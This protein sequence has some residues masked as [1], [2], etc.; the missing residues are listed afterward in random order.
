MIGS[1]PYSDVDKFFTEINDL[2]NTN[3]KKIGN[4]VGWHQ[5]IGEDKVGDVATAQGLLINQYTGQPTD[6]ECKETLINT[7]IIDSVNNTGC[8]A[9]ISNSDTPLVSAT[10][11]ITTAIIAS[12]EPVSSEVIQKAVNW[13]NHNQND[14]GGW[15]PNKGLPSRIYDTFLA[16]RV[17]KAIDPYNSYENNNLRNARRW[18]AEAQNQDGGWGETESGLS[19]PVHTA[20]ALIALS[21]NSNPTND[22][23]LKNGKRYLYSQWQPLDAWEHTSCTEVYEIFKDGN[24]S[25]LNR[26]SIEHYSTPWAIS[27]LLLCGESIINK[28]LFKSLKWLL[29]RALN[30]D[31]KSSDTK[32]NGRF[33]AMH[34]T[35]FALQ[36]FKNKS[37]NY[38]FERM[39]FINKFIFFSTGKT[40]LVSFLII[41]APIFLL[42]LIFGL[43]VDE[44][45]SMHIFNLI[46]ANKQYIG[47]IIWAMLI[48][49]PLLLAKIKIITWKDAII[50][51]LIPAVLGITFDMF[52]MS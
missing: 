42:G 7:Q 3:K 34:D 13:I 32:P 40:Q 15:G 10:S 39:V 27:A 20:Y 21:D 29:T 25:S 37:V 26:I 50:G 14:D 41:T 35:V 4:R 33:W 30:G 49:L 43:L 38:G 52:I 11:W 31:F 12:G 8:W 23:L 45:K 24:S 9:F 17:L 44:D 36:T 2:L 6:K 47:R 19:T 28:K 51:V 16:T 5:F 1:F 46:S 18:I 48:L 22:I